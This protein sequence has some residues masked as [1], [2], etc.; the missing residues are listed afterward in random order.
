MKTAC[1]TFFYC[2]IPALSDFGIVR[3]DC[4]NPDEYSMAASVTEVR[5][6]RRR[7]ALAELRT[8]VH[9]GAEST[10][11]LLGANRPPQDQRFCQH[12]AAAG[13]PGR[14]EHTSHIT[15]ECT[16]YE[17]LRAYHPSIFPAVE[18]E[19]QAPALGSTLSGPSQPLARYLGACRRRARRTLGL[20]P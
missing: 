7:V 14:V 20:P 17:D 16:L 13:H 2:S 18:P 4:L 15:S 3:P 1:T 11:R 6:R 9:W 8:G 10:A 12:C 19:Q 5:E